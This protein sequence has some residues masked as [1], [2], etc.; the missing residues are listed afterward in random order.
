MK[1]PCRKFQW[2][3]PLSALVA[4][5][6][7][8]PSISA[9]QINAVYVNGN[10]GTVS[11]ANVVYGYSNDGL[12]NLTPLPGSPYLTGGTGSAPAPGVP[13]G[14]QTD[15]DQQVVINGTGT[16]LF[17]V[18]GFSNNVSVFNIN[19]DASLS[20]IAGSP[21]NTGGPQP[22]S[23]GL[24]DGALGN[25]LSLMVV[26]N[27]DSD[28]NQ[29]TTK[30]PNMQ[31]FTVASDGTMT[32]NVGKQVTL[33]VG[34]SPSQAA[35]GPSHLT[36]VMEFAGA[37]IPPTVSQIDSYRIKSNGSL[38]LNN[39]VQVPPG[40]HVFLG[41]VVHPA[42]NVLY[43]ALPADNAISVYSFTQQTGQL[44]FVTTVSTP[45]S[46]PCW[47][48]IN[49]AG[50][51]LYSAETMTNTITLYDISTATA[52]VQIQHLAL[53]T[54][55]PS[56][57]VTNVRMDPT[58]QFLYALSN[59]PTNSSLHILSLAADGTMT[60]TLTPLILPAPS[61]NFPVGIGT[62]IK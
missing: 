47:L 21:F 1:E 22:M 34:S 44:A 60:E 11:N 31:T 40:D 24:F 17:T 10:I 37:A 59:S 35:I 51:R 3:W 49:A 2:W 46:L 61:G 4:I 6:L 56:S 23:I 41:E 9:A 32:H 16:L 28:P 5:L 33:Q 36:F 43:A 18:N 29:I 58:G 48:G 27:H 50:T 19:S 39:S 54:T 15:D 55:S 14:L 26:V 57:G 12:G 42:L 13:L 53:T 8:G 38:T 30:K 25:G 20:P 7:L 45:G 62:L 52:P